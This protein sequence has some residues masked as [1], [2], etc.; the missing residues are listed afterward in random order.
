[1]PPRLLLVLTENQTLRP[2]PDVGDL[3]AFAVRPSR[4]GSTGSW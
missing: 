2:P 3:V 4:P 1:M